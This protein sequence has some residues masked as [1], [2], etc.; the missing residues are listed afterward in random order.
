MRVASG[1]DGLIEATSKA[2]LSEGGKTGEKP[3]AKKARCHADSMPPT[4]VG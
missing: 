1:T 3:G 2:N 4:E